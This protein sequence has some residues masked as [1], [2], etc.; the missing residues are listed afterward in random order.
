MRSVG[1]H[2]LL[3]SV[4]SHTIVGTETLANSDTLIEFISRTIFHLKQQVSPLIIL[5][6]DPLSSLITT[7]DPSLDVLSTKASLPSENW[8]VSSSSPPFFHSCPHSLLANVR[9]ISTFIEEI[10]QNLRQTLNKTSSLFLLSSPLLLFQS[11]TSLMPGE[12]DILL[13]GDSISWEQIVYI[14]SLIDSYEFKATCLDRQ[15]HDVQSMETGIPILLLLHSHLLSS[16]EQR[17][18][19]S[20]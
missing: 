16:N 20:K 9:M 17:H 10:C 4:P 2:S 15:L 12:F 3:A 14:S 18:S 7:L 1:C 8:D 19:C 6:L 11:F 5:R 13:S